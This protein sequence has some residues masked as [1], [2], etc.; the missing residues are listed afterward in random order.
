MW[1]LTRW[2]MLLPMKPHPLADLF[3]RMSREDFA[4]LSEDINANG[5]RDPIIT[6]DGLIL[7]GRHRYHA[8]LENEMEPSFIEFTGDNPV[9]F[10]LSKNIHRRHLSASQRAVIV[11]ECVSWLDAHRP[12]TRERPANDNDDC[13]SNNAQEEQGLLVRTG[14]YLARAANVSPRTID[15]AKAAIRAGRGEDV[16]AGKVSVKQLAR[17]AKEA[18]KATAERA[19]HTDDEGIYHDPSETGPGEEE[20]GQTFDEITKENTEL[21]RLNEALMKDDSKAEIAAWKA[22]FDGMCGRVNQLMTTANE[23]EKTLNYRGNLIARVKKILG[24]EKDNAIISTLE[25]RL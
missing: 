14:A 17:E 9:A 3:P 16:K 10:V 20:L 18:R 15:D 22:K 5:L 7:D 13:N 25:A 2:G 1:S 11:A 4:Q 19:M 24:I 12:S 6:L 23:M 8:C 21:K